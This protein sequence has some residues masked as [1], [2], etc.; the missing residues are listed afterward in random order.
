VSAG[1]IRV[2]GGIRVRDLRDGVLLA[3]APEA[4]EE[5]ANRLFVTLG[6]RLR[7]ARLRG[8]R[9]AVPAARS[10]LL[11]F[12]PLRLSAERLRAELER[13]S[14]AAPEAGGSGRTLIVPVAYDGPDLDELARGAGISSEELARRHAAADYRVA[15]LGFAP[16]F[17]YLTG[18]PLELAAP[19][20][21]TPRTRVP[22]GSV[23]IGGSYTGVYPAASPGGWRLIGTTTVQMLDAQAQPPALL[24][25][26]DRVR[27]ESV[28]AGELPRPGRSW[29]A[30]RPAAPRG[31]PILRVLS[32]GLA[33]TVQGGPL[34]GLGS[35]GVPAGGAIDPLGLA[36]ANALVGNAPDARGLEIALRGEGPELEA[37]ADCVAAAGGLTALVGGRSP[38]GDF[39]FRLSAGDRLRLL[40]GPGAWGYLAVAGGL[41]A[42]S[43][44]AP[45]PRL[46]VGAVLCTAE[47][48]VA[49]TGAGSAD[50]SP[51][52]GAAAPSEPGVLRL[53]IL[54][55]PESDS[56]APPE[57][58]RLFATPWRVSSDSDRRGLRLEGD[59]IAH[60]GAREIPPSGT[61]PGTI[62][63][64]G[65]GLPIVLGPDGPVTGGYPRV[66]TVIGAD[67]PLLGRAAPGTVLRLVPVTLSQALEARRSSRVGVP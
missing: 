45:Q 21:S 42:P 38:E 14:L 8:L 34:D 22:A 46:T 19:R 10:L 15:F 43:R 28:A 65:G 11:H 64:P 66:A 48:A 12:D 2:R 60:R 24:C 56:L 31:T 7:A 63:L 58:E 57:L 53:R 27:F 41:E 59:P 35:S 16:G 33:T 40:R 20:L 30:E 1:E 62:Q 6:E 29:G 4:A 67:V 18:L 61:V 51:P 25:A 52:R 32:P 55:G 26:G 17:A 49:R 39:A 47:G 9:D 37:L 50:A 44:L 23:A 13:H 54:P 3:D 5:S 36:R